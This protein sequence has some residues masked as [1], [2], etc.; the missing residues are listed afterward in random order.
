PSGGQ[1]RQASQACG[2]RGRTI[3]CS[4]DAAKA[5][6]FQ[7]AAANCANHAPPTCEARCTALAA[8]LQQH[9]LA[10]GND[11]DKCA[12]VRQSALDRC[13]QEMCNPT[14]ETCED[15]C[16]DFSRGVF[17]QC[18]NAGGTST[19]CGNQADDARAHCISEHCQ[20]TPEPTCQDRCTARARAA[21]EQCVAAGHPADACRTPVRQLP[22]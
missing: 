12:T 18:M 22:A 15:R 2:R 21:A 7:P 16:T 20:T 14:A 10:E 13:T 6:H 17:A 4:P 19:D 9:C 3:R 5:G 1:R 11:A 8:G